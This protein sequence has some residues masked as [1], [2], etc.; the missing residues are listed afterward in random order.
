MP[1]GS[2]YAMYRAL[3]LLTYEWQQGLRARVEIANRFVKLHRAFAHSGSPHAVLW[4]MEYFVDVMCALANAHHLWHNA[5]AGSLMTEIPDLHVHL[6]R[7]R[8][9]VQ[10]FSRSASSLELELHP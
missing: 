8:H 7:M 4:Q 10:L 1:R 9:F 3:C 5:P 6:A 2:R